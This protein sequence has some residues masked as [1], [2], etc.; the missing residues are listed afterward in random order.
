MI[1][2]VFLLLIFFVWVHSDIEREAQMT[3]NLPSPDA[4]T[5]QQDLGETLVIFILPGGQVACGSLN[6]R[7]TMDELKQ[8]LVA[9]YQADK[10]I[11]VLIETYPDGIYGNLVEVLDICR[12]PGF[13]LEN[14]IYTDN[15]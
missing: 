1:D 12:R 13:K 5:T 4:E 6:N 2:V 9:Q 7:V 14:V 10:E 15:R 11:P 3:I 8:I